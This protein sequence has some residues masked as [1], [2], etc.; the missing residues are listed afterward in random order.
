MSESERVAGM[1][2]RLQQ[3]ALAAGW[4]WDEAAECWLEPEGQA[5]S[6]AVEWPGV[7]GG[8]P[9]CCTLPDA[10]R[11]EGLAGNYRRLV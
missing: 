7:R 3:L 10:G 9:G 8:A 11:V 2:V 4:R 5:A 6:G 1:L